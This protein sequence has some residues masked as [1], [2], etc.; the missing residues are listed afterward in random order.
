MIG[1]AYTLR[2]LQDS[3]TMLVE[4]QASGLTT[5]GEARSLLESLISSARASLGAGRQS[6]PGRPVGRCP[7]CGTALRALKVNTSPANRT[8]DDSTAVLLCV[9][10]HYEDWR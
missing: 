2:Q 6:A 3:R 1:P 5:I 8:G 10:C 4:L 9:R 7:H